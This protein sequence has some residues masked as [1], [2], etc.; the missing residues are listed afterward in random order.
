M[1]VHR[2]AHPE[3]EDARVGRVAG[4]HVFHDPFEASLAHGRLAVGEEHDAVGP[5][6]IDLDLK[7]LRERG[8]DVCAAAGLH[9]IDER[10]RLFDAGLR[11]NQLSG[12]RF[13]VGAEAHDVEAII[14][15]EAAHAVLQRLLGSP[16]LLSRHAARRIDHKAHILVDHFVGG[17]FDLGSDHE[18]EEPVLALLP[19]CQQIEAEVLLREGVVQEKVSIEQAL[20]FLEAHDG[21]TVALAADAHLVGRGVHGFDGHSRLERHREGEI[22]ERAR[23][24]L[25]CFERIHVLPDARVQLDHL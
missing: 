19:V 21:L 6:G 11:R 7:R 3:H 23:C 20:V 13:H 24:A 8:V 4:G 18:H 25:A 14:G 2:V 5:L 16:D 1:G 10:E 12:H 9:P 17:H 15:A 22:L